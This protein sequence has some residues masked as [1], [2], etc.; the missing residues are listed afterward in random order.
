MIKKRNLFENL[1]NNDLY[2]VFLFTSP[3]NI[4]LSLWTHPWFVINK[5]G[6]ISRYEVRYKKNK[7]LGH[8]HKDN[9]PPFDGVE[10]FSFASYP[11]W[12]ANLIDKIE[13]EENSPAQKMCEFIENSINNYKDK[14]IY[15]LFGPNSN[16]YVQWIL[17][18]NPEFNGKLKWNA[19]GN[20]Y[21]N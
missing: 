16:T 17:N 15:F 5:K 9:L 12:N 4:P 8:I 3:A 20:N 11:R 1:V 7:E 6:K 14:N 18:N 2:Q 19:L 13:G 21:K 10:V